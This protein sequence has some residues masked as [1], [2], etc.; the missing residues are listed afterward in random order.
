M[1]KTR[2]RTV[3]DAL[4]KAHSRRYGPGILFN[5]LSIG[6]A[7]ILS[8]LQK[9][10]VKYLATYTIELPHRFLFSSKLWHQWQ[11]S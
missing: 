2:N 5:S 9:F 8:N 6:R 1:Q 3:F 7:I 11:G 4:L 10:L